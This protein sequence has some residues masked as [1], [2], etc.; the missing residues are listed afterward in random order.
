MFQTEDPLLVPHPPPCEA[1]TSTPLATHVRA[2]DH[3]AASM[4]AV[5]GSPP[6]RAHIR[7]LHKTNAPMARGAKAW[8][9]SPSPRGGLAAYSRVRGRGSLRC[10]CYGSTVGYYNN[11]RVLQKG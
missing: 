11:R 1:P 2:D 10:H 4:L 5:P 8:V 6:P 7:L 3:T 9:T